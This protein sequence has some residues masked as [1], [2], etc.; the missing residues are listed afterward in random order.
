MDVRRLHQLLEA[1]GIPRDFDLLSLDIEGEDV[2][3]LNDLIGG[4]AYRP[5]WVIIEAS[6]NYA[7]RSLDDLELVESVR[8]ISDCGAD[9]GSFDSEVDGVSMFRMADWVGG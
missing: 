1:R 6:A 8:E 3:V 2:R 4:S 9:G 5:R 7:T